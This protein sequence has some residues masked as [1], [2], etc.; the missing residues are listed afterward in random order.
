MGSGK[1]I[2]L[3]RFKNQAG[4]IMGSASFLI[5]GL[6]C[7]EI[8]IFV[9]AVDLQRPLETENKNEIGTSWSV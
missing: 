1:P 9:P 8:K 5:F 7:G 2:S 6:S 4:W 3:N